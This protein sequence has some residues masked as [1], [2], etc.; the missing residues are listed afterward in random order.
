[1]F[2][3]SLQAPRSL[4]CET[5]DVRAS[6]GLNTTPRCQTRRLS[7][8]TDW[9]MYFFELLRRPELWTDAWQT[10]SLL[11]AAEKRTT[12]HDFFSRAWSCCRSPSCH[13]RRVVDVSS[14]SSC[15][16]RHRAIVVVIRPYGLL[17]HTDLFGFTSSFLW[18]YTFLYC[19]S[20]DDKFLVFIH[21]C[22]SVL[23]KL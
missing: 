11:C 10:L 9:A 5:G 12:N 16:R 4:T 8:P 13:R 20:D 1:M 18:S 19:S 17:V 15:R 21:C 2:G 23:F 6:S 3:M 14:S 22:I 7:V